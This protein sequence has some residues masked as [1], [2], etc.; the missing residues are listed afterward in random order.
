MSLYLKSSLDRFI[1]DN[2]YLDTEVY[3]NLKSSLD[4]FIV[5][6]SS[7]TDLVIAFKIQFG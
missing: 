5:N 2:H 4:R 7:K 3:A 6:G 1:A